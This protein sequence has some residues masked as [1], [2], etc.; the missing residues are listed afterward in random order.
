[1]RWMHAV[2]PY[3]LTEVFPRSKWRY[4]SR[5]TIGSVSLFSIYMES[6]ACPGRR[7]RGKGKTMC[8]GC[9]GRRSHG[10]GNEG[11]GGL[12]S[13]R[14]YS[15]STREFDGQLGGLRR[16]K[17]RTVAQSRVFARADE[18]ARAHSSLACCHL[19]ARFFIRFKEPKLFYFSKIIL[20]ISSFVKSQF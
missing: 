18:A 15:K 20:R 1:M 10:A 17:A 8:S 9:S 11:A 5:V 14:C 6:N 12:G 19:S 7:T 4:V 2:I 3:I 13:C 16:S